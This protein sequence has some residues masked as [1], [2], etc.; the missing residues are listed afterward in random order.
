MFVGHYGEVVEVPS[1]W[2]ADVQLRGLTEVVY[3]HRKFDDD[4]G[5]KPFQPKPVDYKLENFAPTGLVELLV[6]PKN[7]PGGLGSLAKIRLA[8]EK[9]LNQ[10]GADYK[11]SQETEGGRWPSGTFHVGTH[12]P[13]RLVQTYTE[14]PGE[15]YILTLGESLEPGAFGL[16]ADRVLDYRLAG[17]VVSDSLCKHLLAVHDRTPA[18]KFFENA[19]DL[20]GIFYYFGLP[21]FWALFASSIA[22]MLFLAA[23]P[24]KSARSAKIRLL[25]RSLL[26]FSLI[27][28][29]AGFF[30]AYVPVSFGGVVW[31]RSE[32]ALLIAAL[33]NPLIAWGAA[34]GF[35]S[36]HV[37]RVMLTIAGLA[38]A[39]MVLMALGPRSNSAAPVGELIITTTLALYFWG[40]VNASVFALAFGEMAQR[41]A[42]R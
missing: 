4:F 35:G 40:M 39:W 2:S 10:S 31:R 29:L 14:S 27:S 7:A 34:R 28:A 5:R 21:R 12:R 24:S 41:E 15:F 37:R 36:T 13:Y 22:V 20:S 26:L 30:I 19:S 16:N 42:R 38:V 32:D 33:I 17:D 6:I 8:K 3:F 9:E 11:I 25:G 23:W 18:G 1:N